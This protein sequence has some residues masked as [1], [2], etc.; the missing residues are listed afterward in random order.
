LGALT[1]EDQRQLDSAGFAAPQPVQNARGA[2]VGEAR[3]VFAL[4]R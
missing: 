2:V 3:A 1:A 4:E